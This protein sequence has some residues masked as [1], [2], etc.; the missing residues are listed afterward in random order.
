VAEPLPRLAAQLEYRRGKG[1]E[2][3]PDEQG[4]RDEARDLLG[5]DPFQP[6]APLRVA[7]SIERKGGELVAKLQILDGEGHALWQ[8]SFGT[9]GPCKTLVETMVL[10][11]VVKLEGLAG[12]AAPPAPPPPAPA[13]EPPRPCPP[14]PP[15]PPA[16]AREAKGPPAAQG[17]ALR[18][19]LGLTPLIALGITP[20]AAGGVAWSLEGRW[21]GW[22]LAFEGRALRSL[23]PEVGHVGVS[24]SYLG[25]GVALCLRGDLLFGC[26]RLEVGALWADPDAPFKV[27]PEAAPVFG[28]AVRLGAEQPLSERV[29]LSG[30]VDLLGVVTHAVLRLEA[31][32]AGEAD[33]LL[34]ELSHGAAAIGVGVLAA[35]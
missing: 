11:V 13:P 22:S 34:W 35:F 7:T 9:S 31:D 20:N 26:G 28:L 25:S 3:C 10:D 32:R 16:P 12:K 24:M 4:L 33:R 2:R 21:P 29:A 8:D 23:S 6:D 14:P 19:R 15:C 18:R 27:R 5:Y 30:Y 17:A 1:A